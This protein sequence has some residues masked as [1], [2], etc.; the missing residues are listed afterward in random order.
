MAPDELTRLDDLLISSARESVLK[1]DSPANRKSAI[2][3]HGAAE[4]KMLRHLKGLRAP[5]ALGTPEAEAAELFVA[6]AQARI[7]T[8]RRAVRLVRSGRVEDARRALIGPT[9]AAQQRAFDGAR[10]RY[11]AAIAARA[12]RRTGGAAAVA[13]F[14]GLGLAGAGT[15]AG[16][17]R[18]HSLSR[19]VARDLA[20]HARYAGDVEAA[21]ADLE[22]RLREQREDL[23]R[24]REE[25]EAQRQKGRRSDARAGRLTSAV[26]SSNDVVMICEGGMFGQPLRV[27]YV[28]PAFERMTGYSRAELVVGT[29][30]MLQGPDTD[31]ATVAFLRGRLAAFEPPRSNCS[32]TRRT[33]QSSGSS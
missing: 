29:P 20:D 26:E 12:R 21:R 10:A 31:P 4:E 28:N 16:A 14:G 27:L 19:R 32:T 2:Q 11:E 7:A 30:K 6:A 24:T 15:L 22:A 8:E 3:L 17:R 13:L 25:L 5:L 1:A 23:A 33:A 9:Y 18:W